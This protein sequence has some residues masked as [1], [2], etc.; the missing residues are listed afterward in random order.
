MQWQPDA[1]R[2]KAAKAT[3]HQRMESMPQ[4][5][6][7]HCQ[8][9]TSETNTENYAFP[10]MLPIPQEFLSSRSIQGMADFNFDLANEEFELSLVINRKHWEDDQ[11]GLINAR[12]G[13]LAEAWGTFNNSRFT[14][15]LTNGNVAGN[16]GFDGVVFHGDS[17]TIG[18]SGTIDNNLTAAAA[19][20]GTGL[21]TTPTTA[22]LL[23]QLQ[24]IKATMGRYGDD[25]GRPFNDA[26]LA[27]MRVVI[28]PEYERPFMEATQSTLI[29]GGNDNPFG[30][31]IAE[32][33]VSNYLSGSTEMFVQLVAS[34]R[35]PFIYQK[36]TEL[37][38]VILD[39][40]A[41]VALHNGVLVLT[42]IRDRFGYGEP[43]RS[44][45][46]TWS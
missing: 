32:F 33:D 7:N 38:I 20:T 35:M 22:E 17:R 25:K 43:R 39:D 18:A 27:K 40:V 4:F 30:K 46:F 13:E 23:E 15:L 24:V 3:F 45:L 34:E 11:T 2:N 8:Q 1:L 44:L 42:R 31:G 14:T 16:T 6:Q 28:P 5:W 26:A 29:G 10:G 37:E 41:N 19:Q 21:T 12:I 36:R 9:E